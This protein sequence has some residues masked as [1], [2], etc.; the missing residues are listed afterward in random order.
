[1]FI[2]FS[3]SS[4]TKASLYGAILFTLQEAHLLPVSKSTLICLFTVFMAT[5]KVGPG[6]HTRECASYRVWGKYALTQE[7]VQIN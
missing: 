5:T 6:V 2:K 4:P 1:M 7:I 3:L